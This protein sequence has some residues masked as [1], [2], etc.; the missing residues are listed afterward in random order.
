MDDGS[1]AEGLTKDKIDTSTTT[2]A[3]PSKSESSRYLTSKKSLRILTRPSPAPNDDASTTPSPAMKT[4]PTVQPRRSTTSLFNLFS[5]PKVEK[6]RGY[7]GEVPAP[8]DK[9]SPPLKSAL[10]TSG[11]PIRPAST[12]KE[13]APRTASAL[14]VRPNLGQST[15]AEKS[16]DAKPG[17]WMPPPLFQAFA[18]SVKHG[19]AEVSTSAV[20][21]KEAPAR[22]KSSKEKERRHSMESDNSA[23]TNKTALTMKG[24]INSDVPQK[25]IILLESGHLLQYEQHGS[26]NRLPEKVLQLCQDS[27]AM[28]C[29][30][31]SSKQHAMRVIQS[32]A[33]K[34][35]SLAHTFSRLTRR[36]ASS[37]RDASSLILIFAESQQ[38][39]EWM[40]AVRSKIAELCQPVG[41]KDSPVQR[42][43]DSVIGDVARLSPAIP[44]PPPPTEKEIVPARL[45]TIPDERASLAPQ[46]PP[47]RKS[48]FDDLDDGTTDRKGSLEVL[49]EEAEKL[50]SGSKVPAQDISEDKRSSEAP[51]FASSS[52]TTGD[53]H[54]LNN[55]RNSFRMSYLSNGTSLTSRS[56]SLISEPSSNA[57]SL[58]HGNDST[59][60]SPYRSLSSYQPSK[61]R[62]QMAA[63]PTSRPISELPPNASLLGQVTSTV[64]PSVSASPTKPAPVIARPPSVPNFQSLTAQPDVLVT[65]SRKEATPPILEEDERPESIV[66]DLPP[67]S[68]WSLKT[69]SKNRHSFV[70]P[71]LTE[72]QLKRM[73]S[74]PAMATVST[75][76]PSRRASQ[77]FRLPLKINP[78]TPATRPPLRNKSNRNTFSPDAAAH[79]SKVFT[80]EAKVDPRTQRMSMGPATYS[81]AEMRA[82]SAQRLSLFPSP[83]LSQDA[84]IDDRRRT[85]LNT[86]T[87]VS[88]DAI[89]VRRASL[90]RPTSLQVRT[91]RAPFVSSI[92]NSIHAEPL[93]EKISSTPSPG[94]TSAPPI[95]SLKPS[96]SS[97]AISSMQVRDVAR[98][99]SPTDPF[100]SGRTL[101]GDSDHAIYMTRRQSY[102]PQRPPSSGSA[103]T[104]PLPMSPV[105]PMGNSFAQRRVSQRHSY[106]PRTSTMTAMAALD[107]NLPA[108]GLPPPAPPPNAPYQHPRWCTSR[109]TFA[110]H[111]AHVITRVKET[112]SYKRDHTVTVW[113]CLYSSQWLGYPGWLL[114]ISHHFYSTSHDKQTNACQLYE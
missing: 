98:P 73:S 25:I 57:I 21:D 74:A 70:G 79:E 75:Q 56:S 43:V 15:Q 99:A 94:S 77:T 26:T 78:D 110:W 40:Q 18:Q 112:F 49:E 95:R 62:S 102:M 84:S 3:I 60:K 86:T 11:P 85:L 104:A 91:D 4:T 93:N 32:V 90:Q 113:I 10:K 76:Q 20:T 101:P 55:L 22:P 89:P 6:A 45:P 97:S 7:G 48:S 30:V 52:T 36:S 66:A 71:P 80:L 23:S 65:P 44:S 16:T 81:S 100:Q 31:A 64:E 109:H 53:Q 111:D 67:P 2:P 68:T 114:S 92:R 9:P 1:S 88:P 47:P 17:A 61:R 63:S 28:T 108:C 54:T 87:A 35:F 106:M 27:A 69:S 83:L 19:L 12:I 107:F 59:V 51:S 46:S 96:R 105:M 82:R 5:K 50:V 14:S 29:H 37:K 34:T 24:S 8:H 39:E 41:I 72:R 33:Q 13:A 42:K 58:E 103:P 38:M